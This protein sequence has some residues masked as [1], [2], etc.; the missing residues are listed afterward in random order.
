MRRWNWISEA[1]VL[2]IHEAQIAEHGGK[3]GIRDIGLLESAL[4]RPKNRAH[5][6]QPDG[7]DLAAAYIFAIA[8]NHPFFDGNKRVALVVGEAFLLDNG[9]ELVAEDDEVLRIILGVAAG[10]YAEAS[11]AK[12]I[13]R[14]MVEAK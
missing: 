1:V 9:F 13:R 5:Y 7:A 11:L 10:A 4:N 3:A 14:R 12:W 8:S 2:A 6:G